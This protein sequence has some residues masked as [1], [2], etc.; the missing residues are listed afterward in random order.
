MMKRPIAG[1]YRGERLLGLGR[2]GVVWRARG[3][4]GVVALKVSREA[5]SELAQQASVL[6][7]VRHP[8]LLRHIQSG[9]GWIAT[10]L[11]D[12]EPCHRWARGRDADAVIEV[13][14]EVLGAVR[15]LHAR[16]V[17]HGDVK[18]TNVLID[19]W[20]HAKLIDPLV[21]G[22]SGGRQGTVGF[23]A[24]EVV[25]GGKPSP[26]S[27]AWSFAALLYTMLTERAPFAAS[28]D[29]ATLHAQATRLPLPASTWR[30]DLPASV[31]QVL[32]DLLRASPAERPTL[33]AVEA[34]LVD[35]HRVPSARPLIGMERARNALLRA[36]AEA[37]AG[38]P[39]VVILY[40]PQGSGR[41]TLIN[42][43]LK[44]SKARGLTVASRLDP[45]AFLRAAASGLRP[46]AGGRLASAEAVDVARRLRESGQAGLLMLHGTAP[47]TQL[48]DL[49]AVHITPDALSAGD[50]ERLAAW[51]GV[52][53]ASRARGAW[54]RTGGL[55]RAL[56]LALESSATRNTRDRSPFSVPMVAM[57]VLEVLASHGDALTLDR[58]AE[59]VNLPMSQLAEHLALLFAT[60]RVDA[61]GH[62][63]RIVRRS[64]A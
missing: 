36:L 62:G 53:D 18:P 51:L 29:A 47:S 32:L 19:P 50:A 6:R 39:V 40:G 22:G 13:A 30:T 46:V 45:G 35:S 16:G 9:P 15:F 27:D 3:P 20:G 38:E 57:S 12:G 41:R 28:S 60:G 8:H 61:D 33:D 63:W 1:P 43:V 37:E 26:A 54:E 52:A 56:W 4:R 5:Q 59:L 34:L 55:P 31:D 64:V 2:E 42:E 23:V 7:S 48:A 14:L 10:E 24:P 21:G 49:G 44:R 25:A 17:V 58:L 11:V